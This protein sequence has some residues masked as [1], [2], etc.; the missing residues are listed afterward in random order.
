M[1]R[2]LLVLILLAALL[3]GCE[4]DAPPCAGLNPTHVTTGGVADAG[5]LAVAEL[6]EDVVLYQTSA[7]SGVTES[8]HEVQYQLTEDVQGGACDME[9]DCSPDEVT[10]GEDIGCDLTFVAGDPGCVWTAELAVTVTHRNPDVCSAITV[11]A[12]LRAEG[13]AR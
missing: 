11:F 10:V 5:V 6:V 7:L 4:T 9:L 8:V 3:A 13:A 2:H 1:R 12:D